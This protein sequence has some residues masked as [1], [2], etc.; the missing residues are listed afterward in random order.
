MSSSPVKLSDRA[1]IVSIKYSP[2]PAFTIALRLWGQLILAVGGSPSAFRR[3]EGGTFAS[4]RNDRFGIRTTLV[5]TKAVRPKISR[6][7]KRRVSLPFEG[8]APGSILPRSCIDLL[9]TSLSRAGAWKRGL[10]RR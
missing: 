3:G 10:G 6:C 9:M 1:G 4:L 2:L 8:A 5:G 7:T